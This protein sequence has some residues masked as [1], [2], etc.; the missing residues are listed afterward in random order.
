M[1]FR[2]PLAALNPT[3]A[4]GDQVRS[5][6]AYTGAKDESPPRARIDVLERV[7][8][9]DARRLRVDTRISFR[10]AAAR[11]DRDG[12]RARPAADARRRADDRARRLCPGVDLR[13]IRELQ[14]ERGTALVLIT[15][16][17]GVAAAMADTVVVMYAGRVVVGPASQVLAGPR[18]RTP[19]LLEATPRLSVARGGLRPIARA[20]GF[21]PCRPAAVSIRGAHAPRRYAGGRTGAASGRRGRVA[22][23]LA[24]EV[25]ADPVTGHELDAKAAQL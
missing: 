9:P 13:T 12:D 25:Y 2:A 22:L 5:S 8:L 1:V 3:R 15:H 14:R 10:A 17:I 6:F 7:Q 21:H 24:E 11:R 23:P 18:T 4:V 20:P 19:L 16:D